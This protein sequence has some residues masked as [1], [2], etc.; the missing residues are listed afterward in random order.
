M[1][2]LLPTDT[3]KP[4]GR[5]AADAVTVTSAAAAAAQG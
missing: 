5:C 1:D 2:L 4:S 3:S